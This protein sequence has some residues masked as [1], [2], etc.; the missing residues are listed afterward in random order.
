VAQ[1][2]KASERGSFEHRT[3]EYL[4]ALY[5]FA[6]WLMGREEDAKDL[7]QE[8]YLK[9]FRFAHQFQ[10]GTNLKAWLFRILRNTF[11]NLYWKRSKE[12]IGDIEVAEAEPSSIPSLPAGPFQEEL[13]GR[14]FGPLI[15]SDIEKALNR[16]PEAFRIP[17]ILSDLEG[18]SQAEIAE[19]LGCPI[20]TVKSRLYRGRRILRD[21]LSQ[22]R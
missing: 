20:G 2:L 17:I 18:F 1:V 11:I 9:A 22:Y 19:I 4:D 5:N 16:L 3:L 12:V 15:Q 13:E 7:V 14:L 6:M 21:M 10:E 8:T